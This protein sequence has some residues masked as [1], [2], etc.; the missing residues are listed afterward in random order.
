MPNLALTGPERNAAY[1]ANWIELL[2]SDNRAIFTAA[3]KASKAAEYLRGLA[4]AEP[5]AI[6]A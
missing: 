4:I 2:K 6:A 5:L 1:I 3:S